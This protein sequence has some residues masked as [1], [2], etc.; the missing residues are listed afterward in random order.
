M[1]QKILVID[2]EQL[3]RWTL[4]QHLAKEGYDVVTAD[5]AEPCSS[6]VQPRFRSYVTAAIEH[7]LERVVGE[8]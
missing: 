7:D 5:S 6:M 2:D 8:R 3:I 4:D 1:L